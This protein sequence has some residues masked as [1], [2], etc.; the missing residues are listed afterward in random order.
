MLGGLEDS[1]LA[2]GHAEELLELAAAAR[3]DA[4]ARKPSGD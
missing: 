2:R 4:S 1:E 3:G